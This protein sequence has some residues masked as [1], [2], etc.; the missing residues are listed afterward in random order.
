MNSAE[1]HSTGQ[2]FFGSY[3]M[4][5][6]YDAPG[7]PTPPSSRVAYGGNINTMASIAS[8]T[9]TAWVMD[10]ASDNGFGWIVDIGAPNNTP[11]PLPS[12]NPQRVGQAIARHLD[13]INV[14]W[15]DG[16]VKAMKIDALF[17]PNAA[18]VI[19]ALTS[20]ED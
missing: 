18:G 3:A 17:K 2:Q 14:L 6:S 4:S 13:T 20:E 1:L 19:S 12:G 5:G 15:A 9:T 16:H 7:A 11:A 8:P 10:S